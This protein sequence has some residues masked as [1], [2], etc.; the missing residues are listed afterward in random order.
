VNPHHL[1]WA[2]PEENELHKFQHGTTN[3]GETNGQA[4]LTEAE[5]HE[6]RRLGSRMSQRQLAARFEIAASQISQIL[7]RKA[8]GWLSDDPE[9]EPPATKPKIPYLQDVPLEVADG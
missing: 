5:V 6:I 1:C 7:A 4:R 9:E 3:R 2:T 8:W